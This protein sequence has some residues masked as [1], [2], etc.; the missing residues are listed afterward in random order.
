MGGIGMGKVFID[1]IEYEYIEVGRYDYSS[2]I[3]REISGVKVHYSAINDR[4]SLNG[5]LR[6][7]LQEWNKTRK[8]DLPKIIQNEIGLYKKDSLEKVPKIK[9]PPVPSMFPTFEQ[10]T[11]EDIHELKKEIEKLKGIVGNEYHT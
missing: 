4:H 2:K 3:E 9:T 10:V 5:V 8:S 11:R 6:L 1:H 7:D